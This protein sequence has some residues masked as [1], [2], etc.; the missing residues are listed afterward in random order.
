M[1]FSRRQLYAAGEPFGEGATRRVGGRVIY[2]G[3]DSSPSTQTVE[4]TNIPDYARPYVEDV[5]GRTQALT[6]QNPYQQYQGQRVAGATGLQSDSYNTAAGMQVAPQ[7]GQASQTGNNVAGQGAGL[8]SQAQRLGQY[9]PGN[10]NAV[11]PLMTGTDQWN[12]QA[13]QQYMNPY[14]QAVTDIQKREATRQSDIQGQTDDAQAAG[15]GAFGGSRNAIMDAERERNLGRQLNDIQAQ[16]SNAAYTNAQQT[17]ATDQ[18]RSLASQQGNQNTALGYGAQNLQAQGLGEQ[19]RQFGAQQGL[20]GLQAQNNA[21]NTE[22]NAGNLLQTLG[23]DQFNQQVGIAGLQNQFGTQQQ[24]NQQQQL[25]TGYQDFVN[26]QLYPYNQ[27]QFENS[28]IRGNYNPQVSSSIYQAPPSP[29]T[30][31]AGLGT[32]AL[33]A[34]KAGLFAKG[35]VVPTFSSPPVARPPRAF[36]SAQFSDR[37]R[38]LRPLRAAPT[39]YADGGKV[40]DTGGLVNLLIST[41]N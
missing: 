10:F 11:G 5:L 7:I 15:A 28:I 16:G 14:M 19:S 13:A 3:G 34:S 32:A 20:A 4:N 37:T 22:L 35:G 33:G 21:M 18:A 27:L 41:I 2:G 29:I 39:N 40:D 26:Q 31:I 30:Q 8:I 12:S 25:D 23:Q 9:S 1:T 38:T 24:A 6:T 17:F 36:N